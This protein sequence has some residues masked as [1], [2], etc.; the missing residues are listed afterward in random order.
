MSQIRQDIKNYLKSWVSWVD[1]GAPSGA[2]YERYDTLCFAMYSFIGN[3]CG[4]ASAN[5]LDA[6]FN[7]DN[8]DDVHPF[9]TGTR[10]ERCKQYRQECDGRTVHLNELRVAWAR[11]HANV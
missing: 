11:K 10:Q 2:P 4:V 5:E 6:M 1:N 8:L 9:Y 3:G 7:E